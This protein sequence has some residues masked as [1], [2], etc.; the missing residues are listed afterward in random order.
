MWDSG[1][2]AGSGAGV[3]PSA[4][5]SSKWSRV[6]RPITTAQE[7]DG[8]WFIDSTS[9]LRRV[10]LGRAFRRAAFAFPAKAREVPFAYIDEEVGS[11]KVE[12]LKLA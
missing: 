8:I 1:S 5:Y 4:E 6:G 11:D 12:A 9:V 2:G 10:N 7:R 3:T